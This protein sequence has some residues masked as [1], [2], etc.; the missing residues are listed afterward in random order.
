MHIAFVTDAWFPQPNGVVRVL[1]SLIAELEHSGHRI[2]VIEPGQ[3]VTV[4]LPTYRE[5]RVAV[6]PGRRMSHL[7]NAVRPDA[8][9]IATEGPLGWAA[10]AWCLRHGIPFT[11]AY[12]SKFPEYIQARTPLPLSWLY[13]LMR[14]FH[15]PSQAVLAPSE[16]VYRELTERGFTRVRAWAHGVNTSVFRPDRKDFFDLPRPIFLYVGRVTVDKNLTAFLSLDLPGSKVVVGSGPQREALMKQYPNARFHIAKGDDE[17]R[18]CFNAGDVFVFPSRTDTFGLVMLE[19]LACGVPVA[20][21][22]VTGPQDVLIDSVGTVGI[23]DTD[24]GAAA[25]AAL[26]LDP[27]DCRAH[28]LRFGWDEVAR[29]FLEAIAPIR[30][31][32]GST[33]TESSAHV[34]QSS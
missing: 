33:P 14:R 11:T 28:A 5:I 19:A 31:T 15:A 25:Q 26:S 7:L 16:N 32:V 10:R 24:L 8:L 6:L 23:L 3:F 30:Y 17:L 21:F 18:L 34:V 9:H 2:T 20:A 29:Q 12:H 4:P 22:P 27:A 1:S 13:G